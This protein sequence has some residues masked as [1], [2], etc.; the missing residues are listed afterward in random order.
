MK[1]TERLAAIANKIGIVKIVS[2][3]APAEN[4]K[5]PTRK[6]NLKD[7]M[8]EV[9][10]E[11]IKTLTEKPAEMTVP[12]E[13]IFEAAGITPPSSGWTVDRLS[14]VLRSEQFKSMDRTSVQKAVLG[15][16]SGDNAHVHEVV[17][18]ALARDKAI[19]AF[20]E[21]VTYKLKARDETRKQRIEQLQ[22]QI[23]GLQKECKGLQQEGAE[24]RRRF[25]EWHDRKLAYEKELDATARL[26]VDKPGITLDTDHA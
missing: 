23:T 24:D 4:K 26:L 8:N 14:Q 9:C 19:D 13:K 12:L 2:T 11:Q 15:L 16:L 21:F 17:Q 22:S 3:T 5:V 1:F 6:V 20:E 25:K 7:L 18:D 10:Q